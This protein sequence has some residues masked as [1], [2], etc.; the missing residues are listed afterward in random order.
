L[1][2][3]IEPGQVI[4]PGASVMIL[5]VA[6]AH[7]NSRL[8]PAYKRVDVNVYY[9]SLLNRC[10]AVRLHSSARPKEVTGTTYPH[11]SIGAE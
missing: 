1:Y 5:K 2:S 3:V 11:T 4:R 9:C 8:G 10:W 6:E 7:L